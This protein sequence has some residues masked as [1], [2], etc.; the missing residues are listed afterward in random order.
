M[1]GNYRTTVREDGWAVKRDGSNRAASIHKDQSS[2]WHETK[3]LARA[4]G[5][6]ALLQGRDGKIMTRNSY[7][8]NMDYKKG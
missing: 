5:S 6:E 1:A 7:S 4:N 2:A 3:R 8:G